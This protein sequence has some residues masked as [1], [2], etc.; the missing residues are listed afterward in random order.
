MGGVQGL[1]LVVAAV[2]VYPA[3]PI[4]LASSA[5]YLKF[6]G[7]YF[8]HQLSPPVASPKSHSLTHVYPGDLNHA[9]KYKSLP[10]CAVALKGRKR[11]SGWVLSSGM[12]GRQTWMAALAK[13]RLQDLR[14]PGPKSVA[15]SIMVGLATHWLS[16]SQPGQSGFAH[17][18]HVSHS[19]GTATIGCCML[20]GQQ[21]AHA[22][23]SSARVCQ[24]ISDA[25]C[26]QVWKFTLT[27]PRGAP[28]TCMSVMCAH[29]SANIACCMPPNLEGHMVDA[30]RSGWHHVQ[31][32]HMKVYMVRAISVGWRGP[33]ILIL[34]LHA[35]QNGLQIVVCIVQF[36]LQLCH[37][38]TCMQDEPGPG[39]YRCLL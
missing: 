27:I 2:A 6:C 19:V 35:P 30:T 31:G 37:L 25:A 3:W 9:N 20:P 7:S 32:G 23:E 28:G 16:F 22:C 10:S 15:P 33:H 11:E 8:S 17:H 39:Q 12:C 13:Q 5:C 21:L 26:C 36:L 14:Q 18:M 29:V 38:R 4:A 1:A 34:A 24:P